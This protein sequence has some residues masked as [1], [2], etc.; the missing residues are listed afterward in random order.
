MLQSF[1]HV[2]P[3]LTRGKVSAWNAGREC[4]LALRTLAGAGLWREQRVQSL[5]MC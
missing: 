4:Q 5:K 2:R 3:V 1:W